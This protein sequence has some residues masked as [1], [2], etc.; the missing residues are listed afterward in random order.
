MRKEKKGDQYIDKVKSN[1]P[2]LKV[3][4][5]SPH[6][7]SVVIEFGK[8]MSGKLRKEKQEKEYRALPNQGKPQLAGTLKKIEKKMMM[9][10]A[11]RMISS[12]N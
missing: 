8:F 11:H 1:F 5:G 7:A 3:C 10:R 4:Q 12:N 6:A 9:N 2:V